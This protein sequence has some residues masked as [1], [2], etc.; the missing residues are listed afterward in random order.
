[1]GYWEPPSSRRSFPIGKIFMTILILAA[2]GAGIYFVLERTRDGGETT[3][4][5]TPTESRSPSP[6]VTGD[7]RVQAAAI[8]TLLDESVT[9]RARLSAAIVDI[10]ACEV[11]SATRAHIQAAI[12]SRASLI[13]KLDALEVGA[14]PE[15]AALKAD[16]RAA[17]SASHKA[18]VA[19]MEWVQAAGTN[20]PRTTD[21]GFGAITAANAEATQAKVVFVAKWNPVAIRYELPKTNRSASEI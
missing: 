9:G 21:S 18:D 17:L 2:V 10:N 13:S 12:D 5:T 3:A 4:P 20:C 14:I 15:G 7:P 1:M 19:Y 11:T 6:S 16:L 8:D